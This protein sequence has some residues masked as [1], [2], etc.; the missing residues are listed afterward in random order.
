MSVATRD[1]RAV[2][3]GENRATLRRP[4][5][6]R[7]RLRDRG[8]TKFE[9]T[10][11]DLSATGFRAE[12]AFRLSAGAMVWISLPGLSALEAE[13]AWQAREQVGARFLQPLHPAVF[14]HICELAR[15]R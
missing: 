6:L 11:L 9:I 3:A 5:K 4:V 8:A 15:G 13:V 1:P 12:T 2:M 7:A 14:E 10:V